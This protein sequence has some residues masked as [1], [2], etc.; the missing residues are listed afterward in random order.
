MNSRSA[1]FAKWFLGLCGALLWVTAL[2]KL[3]GAM[4]TARML[5]VR[6]PLLFVNHRVLLVLVGLVEA[7]IAFYLAGAWKPERYWRDAAA[8]LWLS[9]NFFAYRLGRF[10]LGVKVCPCLGMLSGKLPLS[11]EFV[12][13]L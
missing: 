12:D 1:S 5:L 2:A 10:I 4:G 11:P 6:D 7:G 9:S 13:V 8:L 3:Y